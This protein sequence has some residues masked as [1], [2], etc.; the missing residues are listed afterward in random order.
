MGQGREATTE[1]WGEIASLSG[2]EDSLSTALAESSCGGL[3]G[4]Y[5][6]KRREGLLGRSLLCPVSLPSPAVVAKGGN[7]RRGKAGG[8]L[9][10]FKSAGD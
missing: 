9:G 4:A 8:E 10:G 2:W 1:H 5:K 3:E 7:N 6:G